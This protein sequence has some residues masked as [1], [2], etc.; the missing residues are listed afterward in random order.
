MARPEKKNGTFPIGV[1]LAV[2]TCV[3]AGGLIVLVATARGDG[4]SRL[5]YKKNSLYHRIFV[6]KDGPVVSLR[7]NRK[8]NVIQGRVN[9]E[10]PRVHMLEYSKIALAGLLYNPAPARVLVLGMGGGV[11]PRELH[12]YFPDAEIDVV[13]IDPA[14]PKIA[15][16][17][18]GFRESDRLRV[19]VQ[20]ARMYIRRHLRKKGE[21]YDMIILDAFLSDYIPFHL[22]TREFLRQVRGVLT[23]GGV[24]VANVFSNNRLF[25]CE[26]KTYGDVFGEC[27]VFFGS[28]SVNAMII[29]TGPDGELLAKKEAM[30]NAVTLQKKHAFAFLMVD[31]AKRLRPGVTP[32]PDA[33]ILTDDKAPV[34]RLR[35]LK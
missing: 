15:K 30:K 1:F 6:Y 20:D 35:Q 3:T 8:T 27:Q 16:K 14:I 32:K 33:E 26:L 21:P 12:H 23:P 4:S 2:A 25:D 22:M 34:N 13:E 11:I 29:A 7:F 17:F 24:V 5:V 31:V 9:L 19:H 28:S 18:F 10:K